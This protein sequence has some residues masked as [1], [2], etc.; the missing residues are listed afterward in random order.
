LKKLIRFVAFAAVLLLHAS[1][2]H[3][4]DISQCKQ[5]GG[6]VDCFQPVLGPWNYSVCGEVGTFLSYDNAVCVALGGTPGPNG[7]CAGLQPGD[8]TRPATESD[9]G[10]FAQDIT[11]A[12]LGPLCTPATAASFSWGGSVATENCGFGS[13]PS[14]K[15]GYESANLTGDFPVSATR[16]NTSGVCVPTGLSFNA[17][18]TRS[19]GCPGDFGNDQSFGFTSG[20]TPSLCALSIRNPIDPKQPCLDCN[21]DKRH[22]QVGNPIDPIT[23]VKQ[24]V[25]VDYVGIGPQPLR[26]ERV[27]Q[28][29]IYQ[30]DG[31]QWRHNYSA[32]IFYDTSGTRPVAL[33]YRSRGQVFLF[34]QTGT[35]F[36]PDVDINDRLTQLTDS[37]GTLTGW[38]YHVAENDTVE[39][40]DASGI[41]YRS[42]IGPG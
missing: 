18:R 35:T 8:L 6:T 13:G 40:Y 20:A 25:E 39:T 23:G 30:P 37:S 9:I 16:K 19:V 3:A 26:F 36:V 22:P 33:T 10:P 27:Y 11:T 24:Q 34:P 17:T 7:A 28:N 42:P 5:N 32:Q 14:F 4:V 29:R 1:L 2:S 15:F 31:R 41:S 21:R 38:Q 12:F